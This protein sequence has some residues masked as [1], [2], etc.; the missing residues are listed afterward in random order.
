MPRDRPD[1]LVSV[2]M[3]FR[4]GDGPA[5]GEPARWFQPVRRGVTA[6][7][8]RAEA[9]LPAA[10]QAV[11]GWLDDLLATAIAG[12]GLPPDEPIRVGALPR[13]RIRCID[14]RNGR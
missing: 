5:R 12:I 2:S 10:K 8:L 1:S 14:R 13:R 3:A 6:A 4:S 7:T 11:A 9:G